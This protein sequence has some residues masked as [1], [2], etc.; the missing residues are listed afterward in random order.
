MSTKRPTNIRSDGIHTSTVHRDLMEFFDDKKNWAAEQI[1]VGRSWT[2]D[3][4]RI[5]S[6]QDLH[7]LW[8][9]LL[10]ERNM[11][12][13]MEHECKNNFS[14]FANPERIDKVQDSMNNLETVVRERNKAY[15][16]LE[17]GENSER[18]G[19]L[20]TNLLGLNFFYRKFEHLIPKFLNKQWRQKHTFN[21]VNANIEKFQK[22]YREKLHIAKRK[23]KNRDRNHVMHLI[24]RYPNMNMEAVKKQYPSVDIEKNKKLSQS[25]WALCTLRC[26]YN[27]Q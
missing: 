17:I 21:V 1:K 5:K 11:L 27:K 7:K 10:K 16:D 6:N 22:F 12:F 13:T 14:L 4:L 25:S 2:K 15:Y 20:V 23:S 24:K 26:M 9:V 18:P 8:F 3:E 19:E